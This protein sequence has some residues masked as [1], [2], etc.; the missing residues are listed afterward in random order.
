MFM[1]ITDSST[2]TRACC[3]A[4][5]KKSRTQNAPPPP[6]QPRTTCPALG[7]PVSLRYTFEHRP[8]RT[9]PRPPRRDRACA[10]TRPAASRPP[11]LP[12]GRGRAPL[13]RRC[14]GSARI[15]ITVNPLPS[16]ILRRLTMPAFLVAF[17]MA[18][19]AWPMLAPRASTI[20]WPACT[21]N[22]PATATATAAA[23]R[24]ALLWIRLRLPSR[25]WHRPRWPVGGVEAA[26][27]LRSGRTSRWCPTPTRSSHAIGSRVGRSPFT[28][29]QSVLPTERL[30]PSIPRRPYK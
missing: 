18:C 25:L 22:S 8:H 4:S 13:G 7:V 20:R 1:T 2:C 28:G 29:R 9:Y 19:L 3:A 5:R 30:S 26:V 23:A 21:S 12:S 27:T 15:N 11:G 24:R 16:C 6:Q 10:G 17:Q 14:D